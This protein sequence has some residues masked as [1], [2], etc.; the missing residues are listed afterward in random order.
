[1]P[2]LQKENPN[3]PYRGERVLTVMGEPHP[4]HRHQGF[5]QGVQV[6]Q[7]REKERRGGN[8]G[9]KIKQDERKPE[10]GWGEQW[11]WP[12]SRVTVPSRSTLLVGQGAFPWVPHGL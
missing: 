5:A 9:W 6:L 4:A 11:E 10:K 1:M 7:G 8:E 12:E 2:W 3:E